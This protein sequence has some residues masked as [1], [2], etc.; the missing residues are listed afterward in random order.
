MNELFLN[1]FNTAI[2]A[3]WL[4]LAV[5]LARLVL[6]KA[7][8]WTKCALWA[9]VALRLIWPFEIESLLSL[10]PSTQTVPPAELYSP[11]PQVNTGI[12]A[13]NNVINPVF[14]QAFTSEPHNSA[15]PLQ[16]V[17]AVAAWV[18]LTGVAAMAI[19][20]AISYFRL[21]K[22]VRVRMPVENGVYLSDGVESPFILG[23]FAPK[24][25]L[26]FLVCGLLINI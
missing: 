21:K 19:Y 14:T 12:P 4:V 7:P 17:T 15:N 11:V 6:K 1:I 18:W 26:P 13:V 9:I 5:I 8:A 24:I 20:T 16:I 2:T 22:Q 3:G 10:I 25:Y 23:F